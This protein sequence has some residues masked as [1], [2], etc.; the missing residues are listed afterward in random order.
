MENSIEIIIMSTIKMYRIC[1]WMS[2]ET[3]LKGLPVI[4]GIFNGIWFY[5][6]KFSAGNSV[7]GIETYSKRNRTRINRILCYTLMLV[8]I[9]LVLG[10][11][12]H[13][14][15]DEADIRKDTFVFPGFIYSLIGLFIFLFCIVKAIEKVIKRE[16]RGLDRYQKNFAWE[17][18]RFGFYIS[19]GFLA[20]G[21]AIII[22]EIFIAIL[23]SGFIL[24]I[25]ITFLL[26]DYEADRALLYY[27]TPEKI[28]IYRAIDEENFLCG[29]EKNAKSCKY[30]LIKSR[31]SVL[32][33]KLYVVDKNNT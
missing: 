5:F 32:K 25:S 3:L 13:W 15:P 2:L 29:K 9:T 19:L 24:Y 17:K 23:C 16:T 8:T 31:K 27:K 21:L 11:Y 30:F 26:F 4:V 10:T 1:E 6:L 22:N 20:M 14:I 12:R 28:Y 33:K 18:I 7:I